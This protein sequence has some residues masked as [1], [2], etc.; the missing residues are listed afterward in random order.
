MAIELGKSV[1]EVQQLTQGEID[2]W[3]ARSL[4][5]PMGW[6]A[7]EVITARI[8]ASM[9]RA[10]GM[11]VSSADCFNNYLEPITEDDDDLIDEAEAF[12]FNKDK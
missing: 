10:A 9:G 4:M 11:D 1:E 3:Y 8:I 7:Q 5:V 2:Y 12:I 6:K